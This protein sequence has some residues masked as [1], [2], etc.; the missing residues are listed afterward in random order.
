MR[1]PSID[2]LR[3]LAIQVMVIVHFCENLTGVILPITGLGAPLFSFL[4]GVS[5]FLWVQGQQA[6]GRSDEEC[7]SGFPRGRSIGMC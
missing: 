5:Y 4:S 7:S 1:Y 6:R 3:T 2:L